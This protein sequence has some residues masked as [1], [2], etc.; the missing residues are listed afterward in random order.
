[1]SLTLRAW[2]RVKEI[3]LEDMAKSLK[4]HINTYQ[5]WEKRPETIAIGN[6]IKISEIL[7]V[8]LNDIVFV[9]DEG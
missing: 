1:M 4:I 7:G 9:S 8:S 6:A 5:K 3:S 2:R